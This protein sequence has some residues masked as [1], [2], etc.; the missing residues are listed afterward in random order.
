MA[1]VQGGD[2]L[3]LLTSMRQVL[4]QTLYNTTRTLEVEASKNI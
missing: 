1:P 2:S 4:E 3:F